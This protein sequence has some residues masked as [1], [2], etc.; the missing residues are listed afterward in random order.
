MKNGRIWYDIEGKPIQAHGG[1][2]IEHCGVYY[3]Y[4]ENKGQDNCKNR[5]RV[6]VIGVSCYSSTDLLNWK[7]EGLVLEAV[8]DESS[9]LHPSCVLERPK[10]LYNQKTDTFVMW[11]HS[12]SPDYV[13]AGVGVAVSKSPVTGF[14]YLGSFQPNRQD[15]RDMTLFKDDDGT[16]YLV[17]SKD[18]NKTLNIA[19][20]TE[21]Y[22]NVD[23]F[24]VSV[25]VDQEREAPALCH[26]NGMYY[27]ITSGCTGWDCNSALFARSPHLLGKWKLIDNPCEGVNSRLTFFGQSTYIFTAD[28]NDYLMLDHWIPH[29]LKNS[30]Y[31]ILP[32]TYDKGNVMTVRWQ[33]EWN[34]ILPKKGLF[35]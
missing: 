1:C 7:Y 3:W 34:G 13:F 6:D 35:R 33:D 20:L 10:V 22:T 9:M 21:D 4:G 8:Q 2:I 26:R 16:A 23:G 18:W 19:R 29:D 25:L 15:S 12:D 24:Y 5:N 31:S 32:I 17:H 14:E 28:G 30:G 11:F 27:M